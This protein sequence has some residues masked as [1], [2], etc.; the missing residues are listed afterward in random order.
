M[1]PETKSEESRGRILLSTNIS[2]CVDIMLRHRCR[3]KFGHSYKDRQG[4]ISRVAQN[5]G[6]YFFEAA[7]LEGVTVQR[8]RRHGFYGVR[9]GLKKKGG[10]SGPARGERG[11]GGEGRFFTGVSTPRERKR[12]AVKTAWRVCHREPP[13]EKGD[14]ENWRRWRERDGG[15]ARFHEGPT[16]I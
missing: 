3:F 2:V 7:R 4:P 11:R 15:S 13:A 8:A 6:I 9:L 10:T 5:F 16:R 14:R 12:Q 1:L